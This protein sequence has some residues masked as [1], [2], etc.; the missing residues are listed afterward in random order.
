MD[1]QA[2]M[3]QG[4][5]KLRPGKSGEWKTQRGGACAYCPFFCSERVPVAG[6]GFFIPNLAVRLTARFSC[7]RKFCDCAQSAKERS[8]ICLVLLI[9][10]SVLLRK[11]CA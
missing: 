2:S 1:G 3:T 10:N 6:A 5:E 9:S 7:S 11:L 8:R 4:P